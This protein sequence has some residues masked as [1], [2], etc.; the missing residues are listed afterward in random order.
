[1]YYTSREVYEQ[2]SKVNDNP[3]LERRTCR[4]SWTTFPIYQSDH[5]F[6]DKISPVYNQKKSVI[7]YPTLCPEERERRRL[8]FRNDRKLYRRTCDLTW[9]RIVSIY[10][11]DAP[12]TVYSQQAWWSDDWSAYTYG[13]D[14][15][16]DVS[17]T[18]QYRKL[19]T[20]VPKIS[21]LVRTSKNCEYNI[22]MGN[23]KDCYLCSTTFQS[24]TCTHCYWCVESANS[25][26][27]NNVFRCNTCY[28]CI[29]CTN[30][31]SVTYAQMCSD[32]SM[33]SYIFDCEWCDHCT[34]CTGLRNSSYCYMNK[35]Y[36]KE[37]YL[38]MRAWGD[39]ET[40]IF[41][42]NE[43]K[44]DH[45]RSATTQ[46]WSTWSIWNNL[47][48]CK[49]CILSYNLTDCTRTSYSYDS[50]VGVEDCMDVTMIWDN[51]SL[52]Y[53]AHAC[54]YTWYKSAFSNLCWNN[55]SLYYCDYCMYCSHCFG[56]A[57][58]RNASY[59]IFNTQY[60]KEAYEKLVPQLIAHMKK[61][62]EWWEFFDPSLSAFWYNETLAHQ[63]RPLTPEQ[64]QKRWYA[65]QPIDYQI[66]LP[67]NAETTT[68]K[69]IQ[70][71]V[72]PYSL[73]HTKKILICTETWKP[74]RLVQ[75]ELDFYKKHALPIPSLHPDK[76]YHQ[77]LS[78]RPWRT[79]YLRTCDKTW[80]QIL[81]VYPQNVSFD[82][83]SEEA[84]KQEV[85][86]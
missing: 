80:E 24:D 15:D 54:G 85:Y 51:V 47:V 40:A 32:C 33:S 37:A 20:A 9:K 71:S 22:I 5:D 58:L 17:F 14:I 60:T 72:D 76:R 65:R 69:H 73:E 57:W 27:C 11:P 1:M 66:D 59:C 8:L 82:V 16:R 30:C 53:E 2:I 18:D 34:L 62:N 41:T 70:A 84:Y 77:R 31:T 6:Y 45:V 39:H 35:Q 74:Y 36:T 48:D 10:H 49:D 50:V 52:M 28:E 7:P 42:Y 83:Y 78:Q 68:A 75:Q 56:C 63:L 38:E 55:D 61:H 81:S 19:L 46:I 13:Q 43:L 25:V 23:S 29:D 21:N 26:D 3:I 12:Y 44:T 4:V 67:E 86:G 79:L 64:T